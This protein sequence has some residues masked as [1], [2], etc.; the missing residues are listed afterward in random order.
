MWNCA[1]AS[2]IASIMIGIALVGILVSW[3]RG[4]NAGPYASGWRIDAGCV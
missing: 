2:I 4:R 1:G 3:L